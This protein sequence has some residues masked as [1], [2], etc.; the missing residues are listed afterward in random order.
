MND[1][2]RFERLL[3]DVLVD[4]AP[5]ARPDRLRRD[6]SPPRAASRQ[7]PRWLALIKEPPMRFPSRVAVG[8]PT[9][10]LASI[11]ALTLALVLALGAAVVAGASLLQ[12]DLPA[13]FGL[14]RNGLLTYTVAGDIYVADAD[15]SDARAITSGPDH[16]YSPWF[17]HDGTRLVFGRGTG[18]KTALMIAD[19]DGRDVREVLP[20]SEWNVEFM[21][22]DTEMVGTR[23]VDG[24]TVLSMV[25]VASGGVTDL[26]LGGIEPQWWQ[27]PR[28]PDGDEVIFT[29]SMNGDRPRR[30]SMPCIRTA[31]DCDPSVRCPRPR[32]S[33]VSLRHGG[34]F[35]D[36]SLSADGST[37]AYWSWEPR[38]GTG[39]S[40]AFLH[41]RDVTSGEELPVL[42][43]PLGPRR[44]EGR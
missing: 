37:L 42:F 35:Q 32:H 28:P 5:R 15:G 30:A 25:D 24:H 31:P 36:P 41:L 33:T 16:D 12:A 1:D 20:P 2:V 13:P 43:D 40:D 8:S 6:I 39:S 27:V 10:R 11:M 29:G 18:A 34:S 17:S 44:P 26:D 23:T 7:R 9:L 22:S 4:A 21:P 14:A 19:P 38:D 3:D